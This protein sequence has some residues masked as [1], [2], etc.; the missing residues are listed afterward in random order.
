MDKQGSLFIGHPYE[1]YVYKKMIPPPQNLPIETIVTESKA[2][3][4][5][6]VLDCKDVRAIPEVQHIIEEYGVENTLFH[7][8]ITA[9]QFKP[10]DPEI[11]VEPHWHSR[12]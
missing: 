2:S 7:S 9:F 5:F 10:Y 6:L 4:L 1:F 3:N 11:A 8:W 12:D